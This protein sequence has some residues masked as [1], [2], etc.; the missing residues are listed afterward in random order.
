MI[1]CI[2]ATDMA[3]HIS[4]LNSVKVRLESLNIKNGDGLENLITDNV[5]KNNEIQQ[6][7]LN[8]CVHSA[9]LSNPAKLKNVFSKWTDIVYDEFFNQGD[10]EI[11]L[12][13]A[14][15][16]LCDRKNTNINKSQIGFIKF[17]VSPQFDL[18]SNIIPNIKPYLLN[19]QTNLKY[20]EELVEK[21]IK[22][23]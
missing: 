18:I 2:L 19:V 1:E 15:S 9:D 17:V 10:K 23:Q 12:G 11:E 5:A 21:E 8:E 7:I 20:C 6:L 3:N 16:M 14:P 13:L 4:Q 22:K